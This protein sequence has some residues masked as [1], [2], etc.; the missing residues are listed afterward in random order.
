MPS[1]VV[2]L[3][4]ELIRIPSVNPDG[5]PGTDQTCEANIAAWITPWLAEIGYTVTLDEVLPGRP[6]LIAHAPGPKDRPRILLGPPLDTVGV[7]G[8]SIDPFGGELREERI[9]GRGASDT[10]GPMAAM[11]WGLYE[12][13]E[14]LA[15]LPVAVDFVGFMAEESSQWGSRD[16]AKKYGAD[17]EFALVG[18]P[19]SLD[20][21]PVTPGAL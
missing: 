10:K 6:N 12:N 14:I 5:D 20:L 13:R 7:G 16:F 18:E 1:N 19:T 17:Y 9:W 3:L 21:V 15:S 2:A 8:M 4:Q 11:L